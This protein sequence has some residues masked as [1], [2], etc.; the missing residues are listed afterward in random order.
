MIYPLFGYFS[1]Q[2]TA[3]A[4]TPTESINTS[5][6]YTFTTI[7]FTNAGFTEPE[8][9][10]VLI[11]GKQP[12]SILFCRE[13]NLEKEIWDGFRYGPEAALTRLVS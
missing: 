13:K 8:S 1:Q 9:V 12:K 7:T 3:T 2:I 11:A 6:L 10:L 4:T 5:S